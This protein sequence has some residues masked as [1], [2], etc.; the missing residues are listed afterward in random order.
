MLRQLA[1]TAGV[2]TLA[3]SLTG[4]WFVHSAADSQAEALLME[5]LDESR[6]E[7][8]VRELSA[9][10][11][12]AIAEEL[13]ARHPE[14]ELAWRVWTPDGEELLGE[15]G[16]SPGGSE[17]APWK[18]PIDQTIR[19]DNGY[20]WHAIRH[21]SGHTVALLLNEKPFRRLVDQYMVTALVFMVAGLTS[22][23]L[24]GRTCSVQLSR[25]LARIAQRARAVQTASAT[26]QLSNED[27]PSEVD[28]VVEALEQMLINSRAETESSRV[29]IA[30]IAHEL[31]APIQN[32]IGETEV[33]LM[34]EHSVDEYRTVL[35]SQFDEMRHMGD[36]VNNLVALCSAAKSAQAQ[37]TEEFD[38]FE[39]VRFRLQR[40]FHR[41]E[42]MG[43]EL[44]L[45][46]HG[47]PRIRG[48]REA[49]LAAVRNF[50]SNALDWCPSGGHVRLVLDGTEHELEVRVEDDGPGIP[51]EL[52]SRIFEPFVRGPAASGRRAGY[53]LGLALARS[54]A[55]NQ[56]GSIELDKSPLGG[57][58]FRMRI[59]RT[60]RAEPSA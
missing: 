2:I 22:V 19:L 58:R 20:R 12:A 7:F 57:A 37:V 30:G 5:E 48:D 41:A 13:N 39:Q 11:F 32:M 31:R 15:F 56:G 60:R 34:G 44:L 9:E 3:L 43:V 18:S 36:A 50:V 45:S 16:H 23:L 49:I 51:E 29:L 25:I 1:L 6:A 40:E 26:M 35:A 52:R 4:L 38:L 59:P 17:R 42:R 28:E 55:A 14:S 10:S 46:E 53:G 8:S 27:L 54:A 24:V 21:K 47:S 33:A